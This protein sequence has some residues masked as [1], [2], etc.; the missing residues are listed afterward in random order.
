VRAAGHPS[1]RS[2]PLESEKAIA[3]VR[4]PFRR[5]GIDARHG[6]LKP[7]P[8]PKPKPKNQTIRIE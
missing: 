1:S 8:K 5:S 4:W 6:S 2:N 7:K 3:R